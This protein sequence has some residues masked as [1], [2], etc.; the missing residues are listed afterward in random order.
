M[1]HT[2]CM[3][4]REFLTKLPAASVG[5]AALAEM[6]P[7]LWAQEAPPAAAK[8]VVRAAFLTP[9]GQYWMGWPG[10]AY[11]VDKARAD[12]TR[13]IGQ[14]AAELGLDVVFADQPLQDDAAVDGFLSQLQADPP[15][16][17]LV[18]L[19]HMNRWG[20]ANKIAGSGLPTIVF[21]PV[22]MAFTGHLGV[23]RNQG[24]YLVSSMDFGG[25][26]YGLRMVKTRDQLKRSRIVRLAGNE[27]NEVTVPNHGIAVR[28]L[29]RVRFEEELNRITDTAEV[30]AIAADYGRRAK[31]V[32]EPNQRDRLNAARNYV[33]AKNIIAAEDANAITMDCLG[34]VGGRRIPSPPCMA[35]CKLND[36]GVPAA[37]EGDLDATY[38]Y[39]LITYLLGKPGFMQD[40][41]PETV[42]NTFIGAHCT[43]PTR[44]RGFDK[45]SVPFILRSHS[46]SD[47][48]VSMQVLWEPGERITI[49]K[50]EGNGQRFIVG[51]ATVLGNLETPPAGG[52]RTSVITELDDVADARDAKGFHQVFLYGEHERQLRAY[53]QL[54]G[55]ET[56]HI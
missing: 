17:V 46:E 33:A 24:V 41:V 50:F 52:C 44:L 11:P 26:E 12:Y 43:S 31:K 32:V 19:Q 28:N 13:Q 34:L 55:I 1:K 15:D 2:C 29:P 37:C 23:S 21:S 10:A 25:V 54:Y 35:W 18:S 5:I 45:P 42:H 48:G 9:P 7:R 56:A 3:C 22:G 27:T 6:A 49:C 53:T 47:I 51:E 38:T 36:E 20:Q 8:P 40:P 4:R 14:A 39:L 30:K 16:A